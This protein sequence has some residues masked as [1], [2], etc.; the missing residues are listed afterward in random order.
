MKVFLRQKKVIKIARKT[1]PYYEYHMLGFQKRKEEFQMVYFKVGH[2]LVKLCIYIKG[3]HFE[4]FL[5][6]ILKVFLLAK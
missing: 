4:H 6:M 1:K 2:L 5:L 3:D